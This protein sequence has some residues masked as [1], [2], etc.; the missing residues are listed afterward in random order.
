MNSCFLVFLEIFQICLQLDIR[1][2][3]NT[4]STRRGEQV[5]VNPRIMW[6]NEQGTQAHTLTASCTLSQA[7]SQTQKFTCRIVIL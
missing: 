1:E 5:N 4:L 3:T 2:V 7:H 6:A